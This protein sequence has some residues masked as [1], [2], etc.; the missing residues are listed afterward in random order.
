MRNRY[1]PPMPRAALRLAATAMT[2]VTLGVLVALP[3]RLETVPAAA[4][5]NS[6][7][8]DERAVARGNAARRNCTA[9]VGWENAALPSGPEALQTAAYPP[10]LLGVDGT[11]SVDANVA[12]ARTRMM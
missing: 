9:S 2:A 10:T 6:T 1:D 7:P 8:A 11:H 12:R 5:D 3:A 4:D